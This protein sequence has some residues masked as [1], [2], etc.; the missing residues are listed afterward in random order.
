MLAALHLTTLISPF[1]NPRIRP[2]PC[3]VYSRA[4]HPGKDAY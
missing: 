2:G 1:F 3:E 4:N